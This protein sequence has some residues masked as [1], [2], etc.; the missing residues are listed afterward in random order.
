[1]IFH[2][3]IHNQS[4]KK[5]VPNV[6]NFYGIRAFS[7]MHNEHIIEL[8]KTNILLMAIYVNTLALNTLGI[9][10]MIIK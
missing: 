2:R 4:L 3:L 5:A 10:L 8:K 7:N 9:I 6:N 1:M